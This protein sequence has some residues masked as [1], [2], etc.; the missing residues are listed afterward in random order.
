MVDTVGSLCSNGLLRRLRFDVLRRWF[1]LSDGGR[2]T[3]PVVHSTAA[4]W[5]ALVFFY[6]W[7]EHWMAGWLPAS[8]LT[9]GA[10][11]RADTPLKA[12]ST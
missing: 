3:G 9:E 2:A 10:A 8:S 5:C 1:C 12:A 11:G 4:H 6:G 7:L